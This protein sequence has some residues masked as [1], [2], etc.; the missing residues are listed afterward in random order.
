MTCWRIGPRR[1]WNIRN[2]LENQSWI[3][4][5]IITLRTW[6]NW[7]SRARTR[8]WTWRTPVVIAR[9]R[10][11]IIHLRKKLKLIFKKTKIKKLTYIR[12]IRLPRTTT[13]TGRHAH[14]RHW[15]RA[16]RAHWVWW[17]PHST[18][19]TGTHWTHWLTSRVIHSGIH[20]IHSTGT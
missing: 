13:R 14:W 17:R 1:S 2:C 19:T 5:I 16:T 18:V 9:R 7:S 4:F 12:G 11:R 6:H 3:A 20:W 15:T 8:T 10:G